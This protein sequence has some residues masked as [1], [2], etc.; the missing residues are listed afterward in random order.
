MMR[1]VAPPVG[2][3]DDV[4]AVALTRYPPALAKALHKMQPTSPRFGPMWMIASDDVHRPVGE[5]I[6]ALGD[7]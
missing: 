2:Y 3:D 6:A 1:S 7:L 4:R 5:R